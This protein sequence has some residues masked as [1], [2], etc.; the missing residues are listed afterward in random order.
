MSL[1]PPIAVRF[2]SLVNRSF[3][4]PAFSYSLDVK[5]NMENEQKKTDKGFV[6]GF[7]VL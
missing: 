1:F 6:L 7:F 4:F 5:V 3:L 2:S